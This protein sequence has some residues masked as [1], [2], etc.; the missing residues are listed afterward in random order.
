[1][2]PPAVQKPCRSFLVNYFPHN[3]QAHNIHVR[4]IE[5]IFCEPRSYQEEIRNPTTERKQT[6]KNND[7]DSDFYLPGWGRFVCG[8][9]GG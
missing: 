8:T 2:I 7:D 5:L 3:T 4:A 9:G 6:G 1:M